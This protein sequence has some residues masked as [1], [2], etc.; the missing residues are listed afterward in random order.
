MSCDYNQWNEAE[1][2]S[3]E[4]KPPLTMKGNRGKW[5]CFGIP[6]DYALRCVGHSM[7]PTFFHGE[8]V[9]IHKQETFADGQICQVV[10]DG[11]HTL[12]RVYKIQDGFRLV[13]DNKLFQPIEITGNESKKV[14]IAGIAVARK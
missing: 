7:E 10:I 6:A 4:T 5:F 2:L 8:L 13:P 3:A 1:K 9:F 12:K 14:S 11:N